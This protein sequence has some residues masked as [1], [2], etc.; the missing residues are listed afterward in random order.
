MLTAFPSLN[1]IPFLNILTR[2]L[3][4]F[5]ELT[6]GFVESLSF[7]LVSYNINFYSYIYYFLSLPYLLYAFP[8][9]YGVSHHM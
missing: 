5:K 4:I 2:G 9:F 6:V 8:F 1:P 7:M 3:Y